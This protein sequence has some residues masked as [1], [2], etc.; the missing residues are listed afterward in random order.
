M[1]AGTQ[2]NEP[3]ESPKV[4]VATVPKSGTH[5][6]QKA[7][8]Y[9][10]ID[11]QYA[12][13]E[14]T[15][16]S[17]PHLTH[18]LRLKNI[19]KIKD[20]FSQDKKYIVTIRDPRDFTVSYINWVMQE[21]DRKALP[22]WKKMSMDRKLYQLITGKVS[23]KIDNFLWWN[24]HM[25]NFYIAE[26]LM[27]ENMSNILVLRFED[28][29]G[30]NGGGSYEKQLDC[31]TQIATF[32]G[33]DLPQERLEEICSALWGGTTTFSGEKKKIAQWRNHFS[34]KHILLFK[35]KYNDLLIDLGY[36]KDSNWD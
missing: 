6:L 29:V 1:A 21:K 20:F 10:G 17:L 19:D 25:E 33:L 28:L 22:K 8:A 24:W 14:Q 2:T 23:A 3:A 5:L 26:R 12:C 4:F 36:E 30:P 27:K 11:A 15:G 31:V 16:E 13:N 32:A 35:R 34:K 9:L 7:L 18:Y